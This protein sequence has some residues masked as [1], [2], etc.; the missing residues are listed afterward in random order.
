MI[1]F[2][3]FISMAI[4]LLYAFLFFF[5]IS[6]FLPLHTNRLIRL[7]S[8]VLCCVLSLTVIYMNDVYN[9]MGSLTG[10]FAY[11][12][13]FHKG[14]IL[15]KIMT[16]LVFYPP[17][18]AINFLTLDLSSHLFFQATG[19]GDPT[20]G[21]SDEIYIVS[22][23][24]YIVACFA[25]LLFWAAA[26]LIL[27]NSLKQIMM[28]LT[29][30]ILIIV[31]III[32]ATCTSIVTV[33]ILGKTDNRFI[34]YPICCASVLS[35]F[36][37]IYLVAYLCKYIQ[38]VYRAKEMEIQRNFYKDRIEDEKM[39]RSVYHDLKNH[40]LVLQANMSSHEDM[41]E[42]LLALQNKISGYE[43]Y[44]HT[45]NSFLDVLMRDKSRAAKEKKI[46]FQAAVQFH[47]GNFMEPLDISTIFGNALDNAIEASEKLADSMRLIDVKASQVRDMLIIA[48][49]NN[50]SAMESFDHK[51]SKQDKFLHG[52]GLNNIKST[53]E[54]YQGECIIKHSGQKFIL[55]IMIPVC[56]SAS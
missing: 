11:I 22:T 54:K 49:E 17:V 34:I 10:F 29:N 56:D 26:W 36:G 45:G 9:I 4:N 55:K 42:E 35:A 31:N 13:I 53:V 50:C 2:L 25:R 48:V 7:V 15:E 6:T 1:A 8:M 19:A 43:D 21:W 33:L 44:Y 37:C 38:T 47:A 20:L 39:V 30:R 32:L 28:N 12:I 27:R 3:D 52:F 46:D 18:I 5:L 51:T 16:I 41:Q 40:L 23:L 24:F 14:R